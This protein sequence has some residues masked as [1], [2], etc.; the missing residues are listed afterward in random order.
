MPGTRF[1]ERLEILLAVGRDLLARTAEFRR[2]LPAGNL[3][4]FHI[5]DKIAKRLGEFPDKALK[6]KDVGYEQFHANAAQ[7]FERW[8]PLY[9]LVI[10]ISEFRDG[11]LQ[12]IG[13]VRRQRGRT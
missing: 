2:E 5:S 10:S 3:A 6:E 9:D 8:A 11:T 13:E 1:A 4:D 7:I 12:L